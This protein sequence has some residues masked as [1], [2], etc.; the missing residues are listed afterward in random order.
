MDRSASIIIM[1]NQF[2]I[3]GETLFDKGQLGVYSY[4]PMSDGLLTAPQINNDYDSIF[5]YKNIMT[6][7]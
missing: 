5:N 1:N 2:E 6:L 7:E 4:L 3:I